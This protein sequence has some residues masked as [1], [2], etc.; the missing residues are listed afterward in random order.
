MRSQDGHDAAMKGWVSC[1]DACSGSRTEGRTEIAFLHGGEWWNTA[2]PRHCVSPGSHSPSALLPSQL[3]CCAVSTTG[4]LSVR[5]CLQMPLHYWEA[6]MWERGVYDQLHFF[7]SE[8]DKGITTLGTI[9]LSGGLCVRCFE[10]TEKWLLVPCVQ[11]ISPLSASSSTVLPHSVYLSQWWAFCC[12]PM[13][14]YR[15]YGTFQWL[16]KREVF[17]FIIN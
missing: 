10:K 4:A 12:C 16:L 15:S 5:K 9:Y 1:P 6:R 17:I 3:S 7:F 8:S 14:S 13:N 2:H 11:N